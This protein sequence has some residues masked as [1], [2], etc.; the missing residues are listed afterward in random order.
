MSNPIYIFWK[1]C[2]SCDFETAAHGRIKCPECEEQ[3][4]SVELAG[5]IVDDREE[6]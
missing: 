4:Q 2:D 3:M 1:R 6:Q 5:A